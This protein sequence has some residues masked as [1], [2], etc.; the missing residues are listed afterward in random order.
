MHPLKRVLL[1]LSLLLAAVLLQGCSAIKLAYRQADTLLYWRLDSYV[2]FSDEQAPRVRDGLKQFHRWH[3]HSQ[4]P[5]YA[6]LLQRI[7][8]QLLEPV[9]AEQACAVFDQVR[10]TAEVSLDPAHWP[11]LWLATDLSDEQLQHIERKQASSDADWKKEWAGLTPEQL[12]HKRFDQLLSRSE[13]VYGRLDEPQKAVLRAGLAASSFDPARSLA[14]R[15]R[16]EQD[17]RQALRKIHDERLGIEP[18]REL[19]KAYLARTLR[20]P[21]AAQQRYAQS[22]TRESCALFARLHNATTP[23][24]RARA[25]Q[26]LKGY[27]DDFRLLAAQR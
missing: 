23:A 17:L 18:A 1:C 26:T 11:L 15:L 14:E 22:L 6:D 9:T 25:V 10:S 3:R 24:Q 12:Q 27:E 19:L 5:L 4:L 20:P 21:D 2:D 16:R 7:A 8:P 13:M